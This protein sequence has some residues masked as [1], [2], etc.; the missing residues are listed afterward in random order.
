MRVA[1]LKNIF[2]KGLFI[3]SEQSKSDKTLI[4]KPKGG[5]CDGKRCLCLITGFFGFKQKLLDETEHIDPAT[6]HDS[7]SYP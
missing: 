2:P 3:K 6:G 5:I 4:K 1:Q 7:L